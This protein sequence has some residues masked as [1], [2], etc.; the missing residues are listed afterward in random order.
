MQ[1]GSDRPQ[2]SANRP[3]RTRSLLNSYEMAP[4]RTSNVGGQRSETLRPT[5]AR[6]SSALRVT[7][8]ELLSRVFTRDRLRII[9]TR[10]IC[11]RCQLN[12]YVRSEGNASTA[13][14]LGTSGG[15]VLNQ[16]GSEA[17]GSN[18]RNRETRGPSRYR[19][20][21]WPPPTSF[22]SHRDTA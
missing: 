3:F 9:A 20:D 13:G 17:I 1:L 10:W 18:W 12:R 21:R 11:P 19:S 15:T 7:K 14:R 6:S 5:S 16:G 2:L 4:K 8:R 22:T